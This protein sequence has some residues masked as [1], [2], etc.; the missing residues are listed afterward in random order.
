MDP[1]AVVTLIVA[2]GGW[3]LAVLQFRANRQ[4]QKE[5]S[6]QQLRHQKEIFELQQQGQKAAADLEDQRSRAKQ[7][8]EWAVNADPAIRRLGAAHL[9]AM[10]LADDTDQAVKAYVATTIQAAL[11]PL[12]AQALPH[13]TIAQ[14]PGTPPPALPH[15]GSQPDPDV[16]STQ[17]GDAP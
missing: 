17:G 10:L 15:P 12:A 13:T 6:E 3:I 11:A 4:L 8:A 1:L 9:H 14:I 5:L 2:I 16:Q 7:A